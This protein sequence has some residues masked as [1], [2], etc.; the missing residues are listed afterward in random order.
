MSLRTTSGYL[1]P[2]LRAFAQ[3][4]ATLEL[5]IPARRYASF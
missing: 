2:A 3:I 1:A 5:Q 4:L